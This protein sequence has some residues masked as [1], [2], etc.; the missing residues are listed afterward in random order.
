VFKTIAI[1]YNCS[2]FHV[3]DIEKKTLIF[4]IY[5]VQTFPRTKL[6][7]HLNILLL[8]LRP[9]KLYVVLGKKLS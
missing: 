2:H 9:S 5:L 6:V 7:I 3:D 4:T 1:D 8:L